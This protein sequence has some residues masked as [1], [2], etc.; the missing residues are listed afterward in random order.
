MRKRECKCVCVC[1]CVCVCVCVCWW[2]GGQ[3]GKGVGGWMGWGV[4]CVCV[5]ECVCVCVRKKG[6]EKKG[7]KMKG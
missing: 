4:C 2:V 3:V 7:T 6:G 1:M 5:C